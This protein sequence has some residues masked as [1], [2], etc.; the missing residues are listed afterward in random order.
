MDYVRLGRTGMLVSRTAIGAEWFA[1]NGDAAAVVKRS[2][3]NG[4]NLFDVSHA[5]PQ[6]E[7]ALGEVL[8]AAKTPQ[9]PVEHLKGNYSEPLQ[10]SLMRNIMIATKTRA[11]TA[12]EVMEDVEKSIELLGVD[13]IDL[14]QYQA[15]GFLP[16]S[17]GKDGIYDALDTMRLRG[18]IKHIGIVTEDYTLAEDAVRSG[19]YETLQYPY[20]MVSSMTTSALCS[21]CKKEDVGFLAMRPLCGGVV[22]NLP[23][24]YGFL[25]EYINVVPLW[26]ARN[27]SEVDGLVYFY[28]HPTIVNEA[29]WID[30]EKERAFFN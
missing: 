14:M 2:Y 1:P 3:D 4:I 30:I 29:F 7:E 18:K 22:Q 27:C 24:A 15:D 17:Y 19:L 16:L 13:Y 8:K 25:R 12:A 6:S 21:L 9:P 11:Q 23:L 20:S 28:E 10:L 5:L 26:G